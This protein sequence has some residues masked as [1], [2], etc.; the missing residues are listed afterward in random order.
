MPIPESQFETWSHQGSI[1]QS[2]DTYNS[3]KN[4]LVIGSAP[5]AGRRY[6]VFLQGSYGNST[7]IYSES[8]VD[9][10]IKLDDCFQRDISKLSESEQDAYKAAHSDAT[11]THANFKSDVLTVLTSKYG[12]SVDSREKAI[13]ILA[14]GNR[15]KSDVIAA[16]QYRRYHKFKSLEN[17]SYDEGIFFYTKSGEGIKN[18]PKYHRENLTNKHQDTSMR[19]KPMARILK[20]L[21]T[22]LV[23]ENMLES[24]VAPSYFIEGLLYNVPD[25]KFVSK[26]EN[27]FANAIDW[28]LNADN[29]KL[30]CAN[31]QY[32]LLHENSPTSWKT[33]NFNAFLAAAIDLWKQW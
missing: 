25:D 23:S 20:N 11:Y 15:R 4:A 26:Y 29:A 30:V 3:I 8:D 18:Y 27:S 32:Y 1:S 17:Q 13:A 14:N 24:D 28:I 2:S 10:V 6:E 9:I 31:R 7:N 19:F 16:I 33:E 21:R 5:Y 22:R 12:S